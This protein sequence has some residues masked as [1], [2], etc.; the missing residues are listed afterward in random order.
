[1]SQQNASTDTEHQLV[2]ESD[3]A[4]KMICDMPNKMHD[5]RMSKIQSCLDDA[6]K[7]NWIY[8]GNSFRD[9][10]PSSKQ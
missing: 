3:K 4:Y 2:S 9:P 10:L 1:M 5:I 7:T 8:V 6:R